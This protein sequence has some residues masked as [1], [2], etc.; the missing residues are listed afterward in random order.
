MTDARPRF[1]RGLVVKGEV[2]R[3]YEGFPTQPFGVCQQQRLRVETR[4]GVMLRFTGF[5]MGVGAAAVVALFATLDSG[6]SLSAHR[7]LARA[8]RVVAAR[9]SYTSDWSG[10]R[11]IYPVDPGRPKAVA[12]LTFGHERS[13]DPLV[14]ERIAPIPAIQPS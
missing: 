8:E 2:N 4:E 9:V 6:A 12:Q 11:Q 10:T 5:G 14:V 3:P 13:C 1:C 7:R